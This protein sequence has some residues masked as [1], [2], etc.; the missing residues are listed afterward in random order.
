VI[1][2]GAFE[3]GFALTFIAYCNEK[4]LPYSH[5]YS[6]E[7]DQ[8]NF[9]QLEKHTDGIKNVTNF[10]LGLWSHKTE[11]RFLS[12]YKIEGSSA[13]VV[14]E[15]G[16]IEVIDPRSGDMVINTVSLD[17][18]L[19]DVDISFIKL[20]VEGAEIEAILGAKKIIQTYHPKLAIS[21]YHKTND[22]FEIPYLIHTIC[23]SYKMYIRHLNDS[24]MGTVLFA[25]P[26]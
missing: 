3:G 21:V 4:G 17:E 9:Q 13:R 14:R 16:D 2:G 24:F 1:N 5:L 19:P 12:S 23:P 18:F 7:P 8:K 20:D 26:E 25:V 10:C 15:S 11:I 6:F 22:L